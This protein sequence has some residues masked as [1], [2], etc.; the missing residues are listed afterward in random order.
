L[1]YAKRNLTD[2]SAG[3]A[4]RLQPLSLAE[5][6]VVLALPQAVK[7]LKQ[8]QALL[9]RQLFGVAW[10]GDTEVTDKDLAR[11]RRKAG[12]ES[13]SGTR[14]EQCAAWLMD[15]LAGYAH[16]DDEVK[17]AALKASFTFENFRRAK[18]SLKDAAKVWYQPW[19]DR[20]CPWWIAPGTKRD[21]PA[22]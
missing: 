7:L 13:G 5:Q 11:A 12:Q 20:G 21:V 4:Y 19:P 3:L 2:R 8:E 15:Y 18:K 22:W 16:P 14:P 17:A 6:D 9:R 1:V 10:L